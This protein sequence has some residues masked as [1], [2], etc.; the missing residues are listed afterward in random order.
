MSL[1]LK[2][3]LHG[4][5]AVAALLAVLFVWKN[6][7]RLVPAGADRA[8]GEGRAE[9]GRDAWA[10]MVDLLRRNIGRDRIVR[11]CLAEWAKSRAGTPGA[12]ELER[13]MTEELE[14]HEALPAMQ[15]RPVEAYRALAEIAG[16]K[17]GKRQ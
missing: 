9:A 3:R 2:Y 7:T 16:K 10:G 6:A 11:V 17:R 14:R 12:K 1:A 13:K 8:A 5:L 4:V 15:R